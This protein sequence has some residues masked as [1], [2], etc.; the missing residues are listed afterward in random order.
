[1]KFL[2]MN[3]T[4]IMFIIALTAL[5]MVLPGCGAKQQEDT[6]SMQQIRNDEGIPVE[7]ETVKLKP[8]KKYLSFYAKLSGIK[9]A[10]KGAAVGG[11]IEKVYGKVGQFVKKDEVV[12][13]FSTDNPAIRI[14][15][16]KQA[17]ENSKK[18][19]E[20]MEALLKSGQTSQ[21]NYDGAK[22]QYVVDKENYDAQRR[23][24]YIEAPFDGVITDVKVNDGD[25]VKG[26]APLFT[27]SQLSKMRTKIWAGEEE[28]AQIKKG[29]IAETNYNGKKYSGKV[30][31]IS[32]AAD[33][34]KQAFYAELEFDN[35]NREL[36]SGVT[37]DVN[38]LIYNKENA[39]VIPRSTVQKDEKGMFVYLQNNDK[40]EKRYISNG[41]ET[42]EDYEI[43]GGLNPGDK[44]VVKGAALLENGKKIKVIQ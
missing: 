37:V 23:I 19:Y 29:M 41:R 40:A 6:R 22:V 39:I 16:A 38:I 35:G 4:V 33:P 15:Q 9:E 21:A 18:N 24:V 11:K 43:S 2:K 30:S 13:E 42:G 8:F 32:L 31:E 44:L 25:N 14:E 28:I 5:I 7:I 1:M 12:V 3:K 34:Y 17:Y 20:R 27:V 36:L 10:T 26:E